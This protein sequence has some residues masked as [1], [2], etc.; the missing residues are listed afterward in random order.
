MVPADLVATHGFHPLDLAA[1]LEVHAPLDGEDEGLVGLVVH[2][3]NLVALEVGDDGRTLLDDRYVDGVSHRSNVGPLLPGE[4]VL[5]FYPSLCRAVL[6]WLGLGHPQDLEGVV[7][8]CDVATDLQGPDFR[9]CGPRHE[10][11][12]QSSLISIRDLWPRA[13]CRVAPARGYV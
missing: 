12:A 10:P 11:L 9:T 4:D 5:Q 13:G 6:A 2:G 3:M 1:G 7:V 8:D